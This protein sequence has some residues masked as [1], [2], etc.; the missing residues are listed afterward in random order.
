MVG[1]LAQP[2]PKRR[3]AYRVPTDCAILILQQC[4]KNNLDAG[5]PIKGNLDVISRSTNYSE[6]NVGISSGSLKRPSFIT[7]EVVVIIQSY[8]RLILAI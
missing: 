5:R 4:A 7:F 1:K 8:A 6:F 2:V 3:D